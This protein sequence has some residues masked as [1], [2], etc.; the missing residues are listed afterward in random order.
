MKPLPPVFDDETQIQPP[1]PATTPGAI[2]GRTQV[3]WTDTRGARTAVIEGT[4]VMGSSASVDVT[5]MDAAVS[6]MHAELSFREDGLWIR[7]LGSRNGTYVGGVFVREA[8]LAE[9]DRVRVGGTTLTIHGLDAVEAD[10]WPAEQFGPLL[11]R[12]VKMRELFARLARVA[13]TDV[14]VLVTGETGSGKELVAQALH[15][16]SPRAKGPFVVVDCAALPEKLL[17]SEL[18]GHAR[19]A[20]TGAA[21]ARAGAIEAADGGTVF[22]DE[23]GELP[24]EMQPKLLR[25]LES[26][27]V[28]RLGETA[29]RKVNVRFVTATHRDLRRMVNEGT[30]REDLYF[31]ICVVPLVVPPLREHAE[32]IPLLVRHFLRAGARELSPD[33]MREISTRP[34]SGNV[35]ELRNFVDRAMALGATEALALSAADAS[36]ANPATATGFPPVNT[37]RPFKDLRDEWLDYLESEYIR[38]MLLRHKGNISAAAE[39]AGLDRSYVHRLIRKHRL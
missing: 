32:D 6:R 31:R 22:L 21:Q 24:A 23:V 27:T 17:E 39:A 13:P 5:I 37:D 25:V 19:G 4:G 30:F 3:R 35:R 15:D 11:G 20:F 9:G 28:R 8:R 10:V 33:V 2:H 7:D 14:S 29:H 12:S 36:G 1:G 38:G 18:F 16:G 34:W 26:H